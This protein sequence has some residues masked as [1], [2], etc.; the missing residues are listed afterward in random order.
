MRLCFTTRLKAAFGDFRLD[1]D[2]DRLDALARERANLTSIALINPSSRRIAR[3]R[4]PPS[5]EA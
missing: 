1:Y 4:N 2:V 5:P 3:Q